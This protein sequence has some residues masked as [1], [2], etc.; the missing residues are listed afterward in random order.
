[1]ENGKRFGKERPDST[2]VLAAPLLTNVTLV[3]IRV[4]PLAFTKALGDAVSLS[5]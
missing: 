5:A 4:W 2:D 3:R 1:M